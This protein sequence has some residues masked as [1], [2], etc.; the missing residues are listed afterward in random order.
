LSPT[1]R[2]RET[3]A[4]VEALQRAR[5]IAATIAIVEAEG[6]A[7]LTVAKVIGR[8][9]V[10]RKAFYDIFES[11]EHCFLVA[12]DQALERAGE[13]ARAAYDGEEHWRDAMR[14]AV[15]AVLLAMEQERGIARLCVVEALAAGVPVLDRRAAALE[16]LADAIEGGRH[17]GDGRY[18]PQPLVVRAIAGGIAD[19]L[20]ARLLEHDAPLH[21]LLGSLMSLIVM[22]YC[23]RTVAQKELQAP[24]EVPAPRRG[25]AVLA[26][27][28][29]ADPMGGLN[30]RLTYRTVRVLNAIGEVPGTSNRQI[31]DHSGIADRGQVSKLLRRLEGLD[32]IEN[33]GEGQLKGVP[34][35]WYLTSLGTRIRQASRAG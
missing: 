28:T 19:L 7:R 9:G 23:G 24:V 5:M 20:H 30:M 4:Q 13:L 16:R 29:T 34:N 22:P 35:E 11:T 33:R 18:V 6:Y 14:S 31:A 27:A 1:R 25:R 17:V 10:S 26:R 15:L 8:A 12:L 2:S 21:D 32:L 3:R